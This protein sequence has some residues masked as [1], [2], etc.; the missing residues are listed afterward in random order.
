MSVCNVNLPIIKTGMFAL[1][2]IICRQITGSWRISALLGTTALV[3]HLYQQ[4]KL[5]LQQ[6]ANQALANTPYRPLPQIEYS[7][8]PS[9]YYYELNQNIKYLEK[10]VVA[11]KKD[12]SFFDHAKDLKNYYDSL[13][14]IYLSA[15]K[16]YL[17]TD[18]CISLNK[19]VILL[20]PNSTVTVFPQ[21]DNPLP[22]RNISFKLND[23]AICLLNSQA[24]AFSYRN[25][26]IAKSDFRHVF[27]HDVNQAIL[28]I[29]NNPDFRRDPKN[30]INN[31]SAT[32]RTAVTYREARVRRFFQT[33]H[34]TEALQDKR[35]FFLLSKIFKI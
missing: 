3:C 26:E 2:G 30:F 29:I 25:G 8:L 33:V 4:R 28:L 19:I 17:L 32:R 31:W 34:L 20:Q 21:E 13:C 12:G 15:P 1:G 7:Q 10:I 6:L 23:R 5:R 16:R 22:L 18:E 24:T 27:E 9:N 35:R 11:S 14:K